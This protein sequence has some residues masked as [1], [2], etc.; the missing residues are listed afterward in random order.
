[1]DWMHN[2]VFTCGRPAE[3]IGV[4]I[5]QV[6]KWAPGAHTYGRRQKC[7]SDEPG[8]GQTNGMPWDGTSPISEATVI[9]APRPVPVQRAVPDTPVWGWDLCRLW[10]MADNRF[11]KL[12]WLDL[13]RQLEEMSDAV[14]DP[15]FAQD[16]KILGNVAYQRHLDL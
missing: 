8:G 15:E 7:V 3:K 11:F 12:S 4:T 6:P 10:Q 5:A 1:M 2:M 16:L 14:S 9:D 13:A